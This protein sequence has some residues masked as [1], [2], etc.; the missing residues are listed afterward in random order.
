MKKLTCFT[1]IALLVA[2]F[3]AATSW[4]GPSQARQGVATP[5]FYKYD[6]TTGSVGSYYLA[7]PT[8]TANDTA[9][10]LT[11]TQTLTNKTLTA[12]TIA[13]FKVGAVTFTM[14]TADGTANQ[15]L[16]TDG[17]GALAFT[18]AGAATAFDDIG[19][20]DAAGTIAMTTFAQTFTSTK[21]DGDM[22]NFQ[23]LGNFG[24]VSVV[25]I[26]SKTG[27]PTDGTVLEVVSHDANVDP[28]VVSALNKASALIV[29]Q[30]GNVSMSDNLSVGGTLAVTGNTTLT[31]TLTVNGAA[32]SGDGATAMSG[33]V[34]TITAGGAT[35]TV[36]LT[37]ADSGKVLLTS[38]A[39]EFDL[40]DDATG[41]V[42]TI[43]VGHASNTH[44]DPAAG[45]TILYGGCS[46]GD[47]IV[48]DAV[49]ESITVV[50]VSATQWAVIGINGTWTDDN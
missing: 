33:F 34:K 46:A 23:G 19:D 24:D 38:Q 43:V 27:N 32:L 44:L 12:P 21:T 49:G 45:D 35:G 6:P 31:G 10:G 13:T 18:S 1:I 9:V 37:A 16:K 36:T 15:V 17:S 4:A 48:A 3:M 2:V 29:G 41:L 26:E 30:D 7:V 25:K 39:T 40:P 22:F 8:L 14:P 50:G 28:F 47:R 11:A 42:Y 5:Y 20:P